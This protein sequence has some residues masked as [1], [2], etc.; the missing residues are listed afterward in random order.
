VVCDFY[1][2][3]IADSIDSIIPVNGKLIRKIRIGIHKGPRP[4]VR[5]VVDLDPDKKYS[6]EQVFFKQSNRYSL[7]FRPLGK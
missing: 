4:K 2:V 1:N 3:S 6:V 5:V 7:T